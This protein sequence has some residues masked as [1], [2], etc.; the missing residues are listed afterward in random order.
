MASEICDKRNCLSTTKNHFLSVVGRGCYGDVEIPW[1]A[2]HYPDR[3]VSSNTFSE[4]SQV[5]MSSIQEDVLPPAPVSGGVIAAV[6]LG[7]LATCVMLL[8]AV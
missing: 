1:Y 4:R 2:R 3:C 7:L 6:I 5:C 8:Q